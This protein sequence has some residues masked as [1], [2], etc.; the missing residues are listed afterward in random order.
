MM[1]ARQKQN[2]LQYLGYYEGKIDGISG[3]LTEGAVSAFRQDNGMPALGDELEEVLIGAVFHSKFKGVSKK[4]ITTE[5]S[6]ATGNWWD[7]IKHFGRHEF[8]C[9]CGKC[10][11]YPVEP[12][13]KLVEMLDSFRERVGLPVYINSG[14]RCKA[15]NAACGGSTNSRHMYGDAADI[16]CDGK[17]PQ[18]LYDIA[19]EMLPNGGVGIYS[20]GIHVDTRGNK[21]RW[22]G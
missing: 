20:W 7:S 2:L 4:E 14:V 22:K 12:A 3:P 19:C 9:K 10:G 15:H 11:G 16:R 6:S 21:A 8:A 1:T 13:R 17:T 5:E 18:Q